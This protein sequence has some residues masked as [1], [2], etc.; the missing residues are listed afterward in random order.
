MNE[1]TQKYTPMTDWCLENCNE[2]KLN[3][4]KVDKAE[5]IQLMKTLNG[6]KSMGLDGILRQVLKEHKNELLEQATSW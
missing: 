4:V 5:L 2:W 6:R 1:L 3:H